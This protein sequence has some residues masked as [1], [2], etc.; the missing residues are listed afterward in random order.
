M[1]L[2]KALRHRRPLAG[3]RAIG[4][5]ADERPMA[6]VEAIASAYIRELRLL[7]PE[8]PYIVLG[9]CGPGTLIAY[10][11]AQQLVMAGETVPGLVLIDPGITPF[12]RKTGLALAAELGRWANQGDELN[13]SFK[14]NPRPTGKERRLWVEKGLTIAEMRYQPKPYKGAALFL[15]TTPRKWILCDPGRGYPALLP[16][17][18]FVEINAPHEAIFNDR[19]P[20]VARAL[21]SFLDR[22]APFERVAASKRRLRQ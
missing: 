21:T 6:Q 19:L 2:S 17:C 1:R 8:G 10:E 13:I 5:E 4:L 14:A 12:L 22:V 7:Q 16:D 3:F 18:E 9:H 20:D 11:I 15:Y